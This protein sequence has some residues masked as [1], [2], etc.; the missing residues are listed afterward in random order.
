MEQRTELIIDLI[1]KKHNGMDKEQLK[2]EAKVVLAHIRPEEMRHAEE[3]LRAIGMNPADLHELRELQLATLEWELNQLRHATP[4]DH[5][6]RVMIEEHDK[7]LATLAALEEANGR[8]Q[9][10]LALDAKLLDRLK[11]I[12]H[13]LLAAEHHHAREEE[14]VFPELTKRNIGG[15]VQMMNMEHEDLRLRKHGLQD[16]VNQGNQ[17]PFPDFQRK[18]DELAKYLVYNLSDHIYK[19]NHIMYPAALRLV[20]DDDLW[21]SLQTHCNEIGYCEFKQL[22]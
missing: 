7:I 13:N 5:P 21:T 8:I 16:L 12:A 9:Q 22:H 2:R 20:K 19:E 18:L 10:S 1:Q 4:P 6:I 17:I 11:I 3:H 15:T 14:V